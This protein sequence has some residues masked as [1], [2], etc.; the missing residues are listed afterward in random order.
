MFVTVMFVSFAFM[1]MPKT[2][3]KPDPRPDNHEVGSVWPDNVSV[4]ILT[5]L[6]FT[7]T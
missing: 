6:T 5:G 4:T 3:A 7:K 2:D 1:A